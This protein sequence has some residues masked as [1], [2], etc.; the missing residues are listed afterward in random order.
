MRV[1]VKGEILSV[2][3]AERTL[4]EIHQSEVDISSTGQHRD[5]LGLRIGLHQALRLRTDVLCPLRGLA[6]I[7]QVDD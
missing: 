3:A 4:L 5:A 2:G 6:G 1:S 7:S